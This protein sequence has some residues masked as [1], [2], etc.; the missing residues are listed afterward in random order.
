M[1]TIIV[2]VGALILMNNAQ[3]QD[4]TKTQCK[5]IKADST[6][7]NYFVTTDFCKHHNPNIIRCGQPT[8]K[9]TACK[10][11]V[12]TVGGVCRYH[13]PKVVTAINE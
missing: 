9:G 13:A 10:M 8:Y 3:A 6:Q 1:K 5:G 12:E 4:T 7:C 11:K 2:T